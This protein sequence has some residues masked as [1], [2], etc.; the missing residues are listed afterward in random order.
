MDLK[1]FRKIVEEAEEAFAERRLADAITLTNAILHDCKDRWLMEKTE[2]L[3]SDYDALLQ[4]FSQGQP[5]EQRGM[6]LNHLFRSAIETL[7]AAQSLWQQ[8]HLLTSYGRIRT[9]LHGIGTKDLIDQISRTTRSK[10]GERAYH[11]ALDAAFGICC[12]LEADAHQQEALLKALSQADPFARRTLVA[13][14]MVGTLYSFSST[15][16]HLLVALG[17]GTQEG[18]TEEDKRDLQS[19]VAVALTLCLQ[20]Y[21]AFFTFYPELYQACQ[22]FFASE[23][24]Q[25]LLPALLHST[26]C[27]S[28]TNK[29]GQRVEDILPIIKE[30]MEKQQPRLGQESQEEKDEDAK[31][32]ESTPFEIRLTRLDTKENRKWL[33]KLSHHA[34][35]VDMMR[36]GDFDVNYSSFAHMKRFDFFSHPAHWFYP[37]CEEV[38][39]AQDVLFS[40]QKRDNMTLNI[41]KHNRFCDSDCYSYLCMMAFIHH[42]GMPS[43]IDQIRN[44]MDEDDLEAMESMEGFLPE[45]QGQQLTLDPITA[46]CQSCYRFFRLQGDVDNFERCFAQTDA[47][48]LPRIPMFKGLFTQFSD[49]SDAA[50]AL[51]EMGAYELAIA[52]LDD[53]LERT[54]SCA[55]LQRKRGYAFMQL[56]LWNRALSAFQQAQLIEEDI[57][58]CLLMARCHEA[59]KQWEDALPLLRSYAEQLPEKDAEIIEETGRCLIQLERWDDAVQQFFE[60]EFLGKSITVAQRGIAWCSIH[61]GKYARAEQY[62]RKLTESNKSS[63]EDYLNLGHALWLQARTAEALAAYRRFAESFTQAKPERRQHFAFWTEAFAEDARQLLSEHF[64]KEET[65]LMQDA[66]SNAL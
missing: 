1:A 10:V 19:R 22:S 2:G 21:E 36:Q 32:K 20:R 54:G 9:Q 6:V 46:F 39:I 42:D 25:G 15:K 38:P 11:E 18:E 17:S 64:S 23:D 7:Q 33:G 24:V 31:D 55:A 3:R 40:H 16:L 61:Q 29:V 63:W 53:S 47:L 37:F 13:G 57:D 34:R 56:Q 4:Y 59:L 51:I 65:S 62:Y 41:M 28:L 35:Q 48:L 14:L 5:D 43:L 27:Q 50:E 58:T 30:A 44:Q 8:E 12:F 26:I 49:I 66:I 60:L 45:G 52:L